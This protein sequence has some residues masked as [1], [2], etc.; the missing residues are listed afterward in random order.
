MPVGQAVCMLY[1]RTGC[2]R[3]GQKRVAGYIDSLN[4]VDES[5]VFIGKYADLLN[6]RDQKQ[7]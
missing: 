1:V 3:P 6:V 5:N 4:V 2:G 7:G